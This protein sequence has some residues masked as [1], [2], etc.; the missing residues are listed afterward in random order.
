MKLATSIALGFGLGL[1]SAAASEPANV[2]LFPPRST[3][4]PEHIPRQIA[5]QIFLQR[6]GVD[7]GSL[8][9]DLPD[10]IDAETAVSYI[11]SFGAMPPALF[12]E[13]TSNKREGALVIIEGVLP[14]AMKA[15][16]KRMSPRTAAFTIRDAPSTKA[17]K[18]LLDVDLRQAGVN[19]VVEKTFTHCDV[20]GIFVGVYDAL[21][22][23]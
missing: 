3:A 21:K 15:F 8:L 5:R 11:N 6:L 4:A 9:E 17:T 23:G 19:C 22:V 13:A 10:G 7:H 18:Q 2:F 12:A 20:D 1:A 14:E 16:Q